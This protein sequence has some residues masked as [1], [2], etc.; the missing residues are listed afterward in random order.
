MKLD[1]ITYSH[2][3][4]VI[5][6]TKG[7]NDPDCYLNLYQMAID[8]LKE[9]RSKGVS[10]IVDCSNHGIGVDWEVNR[11]IEQETGIK[12]INSTGCYK[13]PFLPSWFQD[14]TIEQLAD[15]FLADLNSKAEVIGEIGTS[16]NVMT[17]NEKKLFEASALAY[18]K[19]AKKPVIITH[20]TLGTCALQQ[21]EFFKAHNVDLRKVIISHT[22]LANDLGLIL[23]LLKQGVNIAFDTIGKKKYLPDQT[24]A[25]F[26]KEAIDNG[27]RDQLLMSMDLTRQSHLKKNGG[28]GLSYLIDSFIPE[29]LNLS[30]KESDIETITCCNFERILNI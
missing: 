26:I 1:N 14:K 8:E 22:A 12:I 4:M 7:K 24:R 2:E 13:D 28:V 9:I 29:L 5:D 21:V 20:T 3:H 16:N 30:V 10:R 27:Y 11:L 6:L 23:Q 19:A 25:I 17:E 15:L 18:H